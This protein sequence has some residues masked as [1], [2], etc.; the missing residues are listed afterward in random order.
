MPWTSGAKASSLLRIS[1]AAY[2]SGADGEPDQ[3]EQAEDHRDAG[4]V[5]LEAER[6][7]EDDQQDRLE[8]QDDDVAERP[9]EEHRRRGSSA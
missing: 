9:A 4:Q 5:D 6:D 8:H 1:A 7:G 2:D 3:H